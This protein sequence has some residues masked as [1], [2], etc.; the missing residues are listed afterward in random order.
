ML[1]RHEFIEIRGNGNLRVFICEFGKYRVME[2]QAYG[3]TSLW[4]YDIIGNKGCCIRVIVKRGDM[5]TGLVETSITYN[6]DSFM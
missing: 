4:K 6:E 2:I 3:K 5:N 1:W